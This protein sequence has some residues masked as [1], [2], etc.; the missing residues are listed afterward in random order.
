MTVYISVTLYK[1]MHRNCAAFYRYTCKV[2]T[3]TYFGYYC[4]FKSGKPLLFV[5]LNNSDL[6]VSNDRSLTCFTVN[7]DLLTGATFKLTVYNSVPDAW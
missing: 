7:K 1:G 4:C 6:K 3:E 2:Q 5:I